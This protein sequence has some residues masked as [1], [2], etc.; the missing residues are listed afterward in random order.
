MQILKSFPELNETE[1]KEVI[2]DTRRAR[3]NDPL[4]SV[5]DGLLDKK[6]GQLNLAKMAPN[7]EMALYIA[8]ATGA[9]IITDSPHRWQ[10]IRQAVA[11]QGGGQPKRLPAFADAMAAT[12]MAFVNN[13]DDFFFVAS[14][15]GLE[16]YPSVIGEAFRYLKK[17]DQRGTKPNYEAGLAARLAKLHRTSTSPLF[18]GI[19]A[20]THGRVH[21][22]FPAHSI[23][24]NT[25]NRL[26]LMSSSEGHLHSV[27]MAFFIEKVAK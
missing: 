1:I 4:A 3:D 20:L 19:Q 18:K 14:T 12:S 8:Q 16:G 27:P 10:E 6:G 9:A 2:A 17:I 15:R 23:Q 7:F 24:D 22:M 13:V 26:L 21:G 11:R 5:H 25:V